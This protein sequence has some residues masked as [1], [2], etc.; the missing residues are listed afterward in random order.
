MSEQSQEWTTKIVQKHYE[1]IEGAD[2]IKNCDG[3][4]MWQGKW[5][6]PLSGCDTLSNLIDDLE[7]AHHAALAAER[8]DM[9]Q[10]RDQLT[11]AR[12]VAREQ[13][14]FMQQQLAAVE[15]DRKSLNAILCERIEKLETQLAACIC[16]AALARV[17]EQK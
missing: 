1:V 10:L 4:Q 8:E 14:Q 3:A 11:S 15:A 16:D 17:K 12:H 7:Y 13:N 5:W 2:A 9:Q 6:M